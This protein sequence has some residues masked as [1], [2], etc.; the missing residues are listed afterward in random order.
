MPDEKGCKHGLVL[1]G[2]GAH[3]AYEIGVMKALFAGKSPVTNYK[4]LD[5]EVF[6]GT[7]VGS[8]NAAFMV[9]QPGV[10]SLATLRDLERIWVDR[11]AEDAVN[12]GNGVYRFRYDM[13]DFMSPQCVASHP[14]RPFVQLANDL[15][16][17]AA[18]WFDRVANLVKSPEQGRRRFLELFDLTS[19]IDTSPLVD[20]VDETLDVD[21]ILKND[22]ALAVATTNWETGDVEIFTNQP[23]IDREIGS[24]QIDRKIAS[25]A[26]RAS[27]AIP[28]IFPP[29]EILETP[30]VDGGVLLNTPLKPAVVAGADVLHVIY[31]D[32]NVRDVAINRMP[33]TLDTFDR[34]W[35]IAQAESINRD[36]KRAR[37]L[38]R[39]LEL[40]ENP[41]LVEGLGPSEL[42]SFV[43]GAQLVRDRLARAASFKPLTIYRYRPRRDLGGLLGLL[44]F[45]RDRMIEL[46]QLGYDDAVNHDFV[47][48]EDVIPEPREAPGEPAASRQGVTASQ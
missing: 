39:G 5:A 42:R 16:F 3:G 9:S 23:Y 45:G 35:F 6:T 14:L 44:N 26:V 29:V 18:D 12:C 47:I 10:D 15:R 30:Y 43:Q 24:T 32:P 33:N 48:S 7:S 22:K 37:E 1:S 21:G 34:L 27:T 20:L 8:F 4:P 11:I 19:F 38:N 41:H 40:I 17:T 25:K 28:G 13:L 2:G 46:I 36:I 31:L